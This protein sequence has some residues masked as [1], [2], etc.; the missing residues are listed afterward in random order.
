M[1]IGTIKGGDI[2]NQALKEFVKKTIT[3]ECLQKQTLSL[4]LFVLICGL[5][6]S[7]FPGSASSKTL[8]WAFQGDSNSLDPLLK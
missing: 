3:K 1:N 4:M 8:K 5:A 6:I 7:V 2:T